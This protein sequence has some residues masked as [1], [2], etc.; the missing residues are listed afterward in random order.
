M[1]LVNVYMQH[2]VG[3][4]LTVLILIGLYKFDN[5]GAIFFPPFSSVGLVF[6]DIC[7]FMCSC[8]K[9]GCRVVVLLFSNSLQDACCSRCYHY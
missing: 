7:V 3:V 9:L 4:S 6:H 8:I 1:L 5:A 2:V